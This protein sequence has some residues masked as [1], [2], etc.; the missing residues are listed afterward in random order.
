M[1]QHASIQLHTVGRQQGHPMV[2]ATAFLIGIQGPPKL[3]Q[4]AETWQPCLVVGEGT[5]AWAQK[6]EHHALINGVCYHGSG[7]AN[8]ISK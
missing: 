8:A 1:T 6:E 3:V 4:T 2:S 5:T 7:K